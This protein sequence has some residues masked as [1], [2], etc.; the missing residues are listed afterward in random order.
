MQYFRQV[1]GRALVLCLMIPVT[2]MVLA[3][4]IRWKTEAQFS[5]LDS[6]GEQDSRTVNGRLRLQS[7][8]ESWRNDTRAQILHAKTEEKV[9]KEN[10]N[11]SHQLD[12]QW[13]EQFY[14]L[15]FARYERNRFATFGK[16]AD[17]VGGL[18]YRMIRKD[19]T[20]WDLEGGLGMKSYERSAT[21]GERESRLLRRAASKLSHDLAENLR[22]RQEIIYDETRDSNDWR[23][24]HSVAVRA[25]QYFS[26]SL[27][28]EWKHSRDQVKNNRDI[29]RIT[30]LNLV[31]DWDG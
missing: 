22:L 15:G 3:D 23:L 17:L 29:D 1:G 5:I 6:Q 31:F 16:E 30:S 13:T 9:T 20:E 26:L 14:S 12:Y 18:G 24:L 25:N 21:P 8:T 2:P 27:S 10:Y 4:P 11:L 19:D 28:H 7:E